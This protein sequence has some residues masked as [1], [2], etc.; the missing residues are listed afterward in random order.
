[1]AG[2]PQRH[3]LRDPTD[4]LAG[5]EQEIFTARDRK[6]EAA[7]QQGQSQRRAARAMPAAVEEKP[8][9]ADLTNQTAAARID[10][11]EV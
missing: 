11:L 4:K 1:M 9:K 2:G 10:V 5:R 6:L 8:Q 3:R 7:R